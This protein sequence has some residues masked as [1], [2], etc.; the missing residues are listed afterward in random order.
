MGGGKSKLFKIKRF[1]QQIKGINFDLSGSNNIVYFY[2]S[3]NILDGFLNKTI[4]KTYFINF[5]ISISGNNNIINLYF[6]DLNSDD[7][8]SI[9]KNSAICLVSNNNNI[10]LN[11][12]IIFQN[13][14]IYSASDL[15]YI[16]FDSKIKSYAMRIN[17]TGGKNQFCKIGKN[18]TFGDVTIDINDM[19]NC[20]IGEDCMFSY[21]IFLIC[22]D[23]HTVFDKDTFEVVNKPVDVLTIGNHCWIGA[24]STIIKNACIPNNT[25]IGF[26]SVVTKKFTEEYTAIAGNPAKV[27]KTNVDWDRASIYDFIN[28]KTKK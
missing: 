20:I 12:P 11:F 2:L 15:S 7:F 17:C 24:G 1:Y 23:S 18:T 27:I 19:S 4:K 8:I 16:F 28:K 14:A 9:L 5:L 3:K 26:K 6:S 25:I 22:A 21:G 13:S 10:T